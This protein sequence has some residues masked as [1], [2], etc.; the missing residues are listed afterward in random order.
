MG[1]SHSSKK[2]Y[3]YAGKHKLGHNA[4]PNE[5]SSKRLALLVF[6][7]RWWHFTGFQ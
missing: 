7:L 1:I 5:A 6:A 3:G 4:R 2:N